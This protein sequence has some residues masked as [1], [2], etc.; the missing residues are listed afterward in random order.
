MILLKV[1][2][3]MKPMMK[4]DG[5]M[6]SFTEWIDTLTDGEFFGFSAMA[7]IGLFCILMI[8]VELWN[9]RRRQKFLCQSKFDSVRRPTPEE[10]C[11]ESARMNAP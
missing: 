6:V 11:G 3:L 10:L 9:D 7:M 4:R 8:S 1:A 2:Y 5:E